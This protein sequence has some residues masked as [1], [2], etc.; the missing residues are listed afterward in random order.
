MKSGNHPLFPFSLLW[1]WFLS[2]LPAWALIALMIFV[3]QIAV[4][5]IVHDNQNVKVL[6]RFIELLPPIVKSTLGGQALQAD[7]LPALI[8]IGYNH[9]FVLT[10]YMLFAVAVPTGL[11]TGEVQKGTME[12]VLSHSVTKIQ[13]YICTAFLTIFGMMALVLIMFTG[14]VAAT[15]LY[16]FGEPIPLFRFFQTAVNGGLC[17]GAVGAVSLLS[18]ASF[19]RR[20]TAVGLAVA[21]IMI[22]YF[23][24]IFTEWWPRMKWLNVVSLFHYTNG[25]KV[26]AMHV[27]PVN[28][29]IVLASVLLIATI[30]GGIIWQ[31]RDLPL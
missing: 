15:S 18:G 14:T 19:R 9:P 12:L 5:G 26:F 29:M 31:R 17:A 7:N 27:W 22:N 28:E 3:M 8:A 21:Y 16:D 23:I 6:L 2:I 20:G 13:V 10:L 30:A 4:C 11:L 1:F 25:R 24:V